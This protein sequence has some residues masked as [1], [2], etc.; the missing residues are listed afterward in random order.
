MCR[1]MLNN[2]GEEEEVR[3]ITIYIISRKENLKRL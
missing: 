3:F 2:Q 1:N